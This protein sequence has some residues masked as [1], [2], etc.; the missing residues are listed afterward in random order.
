MEQL[1]HSRLFRWLVGLNIDHTVW[2]H[3]TF[4]FNHD[5]L[6]DAEIAR[7]FFE[8]T[9]LLTR[10]GKL[11]SEEDFSVDGALLEPRLSTR[12]LPKDGSDEGDGSDFRGRKRSNQRHALTTDAHARLARKGYGQQ[13]RLA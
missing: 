11:V 2:G 6:F 3:S 7:Q 13:A 12:A 10:L 9:V 4:S 8:H 1:N 5:R